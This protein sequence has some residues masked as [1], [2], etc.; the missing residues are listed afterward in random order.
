M[1]V[2]PAE[3]SR[4]RLRIRFELSTS[5]TNASSRHAAC[6]ITSISQHP[7]GSTVRRELK[8]AADAAL[9]LVDLR[10][11]GFERQRAIGLQGVDEKR[12]QSAGDEQAVRRRSE[13]N[14]EDRASE[15]GKAGKGNSRIRPDF[16]FAVVGSRGEKLPGGLEREGERKRGTLQ[17][18]EVM[19]LVPWESRECVIT[20]PGT[21]AV[22]SS[23]DFQRRTEESPEP[24]A[25]ISDVGDH[26]QE[27]T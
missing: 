18:S 23:C 19:S 26:T 22:E 4:R 20:L 17:D 5:V 8:S 9:E 14:A 6:R 10:H 16:D 25:R 15:R 27:Y 21:N 7:R 1:H 24:V 3:A 11:V 13:G 12:G 2:F